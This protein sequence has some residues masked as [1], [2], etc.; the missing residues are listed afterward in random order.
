MPKVL[1][2]MHCPIC[3]QI[4]DI[5]DEEIVATDKG[6]MHRM[7]VECQTCA[8]LINCTIDHGYK[9][10]SDGSKKYVHVSTDDAHI[11]VRGEPDFSFEGWVFE[12]PMD[13][14]LNVPLTAMDSPYVVDYIKR[15]SVQNPN[16][17]VILLKTPD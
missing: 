3:A 6:P 8:D 7:H 2:P 5:T 10:P 9:P 13:F 17:C 12:V 11:V 1:P 4:A 14:N 15:Q 16:A